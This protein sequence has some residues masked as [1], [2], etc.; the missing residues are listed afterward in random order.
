MNSA[1][2]IFA[3][4]SGAGRAGVAVIRISGADAGPAVAALTGKPLPDPRLAARRR[5]VCADGA[6]LDDG[7]L[8]WF[9]GPASFTGE[10]VAELQVHGGAA[11]IEAIAGALAAQGLRLAEPGEFTRRAFENGKLDLTAAEAIA[12][13]V[14]A[15]TEGQRRQALRQMQGAL[16]ALYDGWRARLLSVLALIEAEID[17]PDEDLPDALAARTIPEIEAL[18]AEMDAHLADHAR[19]ERVR[20]GY[21]IA[22]IGAPNAGKS[23]L[24]NALAQREA[25]IVSDTPG[26]TRD[27]V[28]VRLVLGGFPVW[29]ADTA[30]LREAADTIESEGVRRALARA[31]ESDLRIAVVEAGATVL[32][33]ELTNA[34]ARDDFLVISKSDLETREAD[35]LLA[36]LA[37]TFDAAPLHVSAITGRGMDGLLAA[38][39]ARVASALSQTETPVL[40]RLRHRIA[41]QETRANLEHALQAFQL[42][43]AEL[44]AE[45]VR[46]A[47]RALGRLTGR[48]DVEDVLGEIFA[49]FCIGK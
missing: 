29:I 40:T 32:P 20:D 19:G 26:T 6:L 42:G 22:I 13:L 1:A 17:F 15:E 24:L 30:G 10:D 18:S 49:S 27:I 21:R 48:I 46:L 14:D 35:R 28:E 8:L 34:I 7:L 9:P 11:V 3:L 37:D 2:T 41:V 39:T 47:A 36:A 12:D 33:P 25:A 16:A 5:F 43:G 44:V 38:L 4:A 31:T 23:S 45:D